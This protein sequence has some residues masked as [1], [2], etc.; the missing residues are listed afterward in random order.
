MAA[1][2]PSS[3][4]HSVALGDT[5][6]AFLNVTGAQVGAGIYETAKIYWTPF[7]TDPSKVQLHAGPDVTGQAMGVQWGISTTG[8]YIALP[9][10]P[11][12]STFTS[13]AFGILVAQ[14]ST[15]KLWSLQ[16]RPN[17]WMTV[18]GLS[19]KEILAFEA[20]VSFAKQY[21]TLFQRWLRLD[22]TK[23][24]QLVTTLPAGM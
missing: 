2:S 21:P 17:M 11:N 8:D 5:A 13:D 12:V 14:M 22:L 15:G 20:D 18:A 3:T 24:D 19:S 16:P 6:I 4:L 10:A 9:R 7:A 23:L 1:S